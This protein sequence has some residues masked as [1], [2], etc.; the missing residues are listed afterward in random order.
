MSTRGVRQELT[1]VRILETEFS[2]EGTDARDREEGVSREPLGTNV[3][4]E[5]NQKRG[6][7]APTC[8]KQTARGRQQTVPRKDS[9]PGG[10]LPASAL[11]TLCFQ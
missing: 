9:V 6:E 8:R 2:K 3:R 7:E 4:N 11:G 1:S 5:S 10:P